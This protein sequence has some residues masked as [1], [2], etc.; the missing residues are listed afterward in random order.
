MNNDFDLIVLAEVFLTEQSIEFVQ[1]PLNFFHFISYGHREEGEEGGR[2]AGGILV[3]MRSDSFD[4]PSCKVVSHSRSHIA[5]NVYPRSFSPFCLVGVYRSANSDSPVH[6][7]DF[8]ERLER[9][10]STAANDGLPVIVAGD[11]N[12]KIGDI[13]GVLGGVDEFAHLL[14]LSSVSAETD[15]AGADMLSVFADLDFHRLPFA[16]GGVEQLTFHTPP[17]EDGSRR[18]GGSIIDHVFFSPA[19]LTSLVDPGLRV[20]S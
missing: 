20:V 5:I 2:A 16:E 18:G 19:L 17:A 8:F 9:V 15:V 1:F 13:D 4:G 12:A 3:L 7:P 6:D 11:F 14:P 10:C